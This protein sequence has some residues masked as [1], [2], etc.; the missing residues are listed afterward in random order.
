[1]GTHRKELGIRDRIS[2]LRHDGPVGVSTW[3]LRGN[4][5]K[6][7]PD[8][9]VA[10]TTGDRRRLGA[11]HRSRDPLDQACMVHAWTKAAT[12]LARIFAPDRLGGRVM[13]SDDPEVKPYTS[14]SQ[15]VTCPEWRSGLSGAKEASRDLVGHFLVH[16]SFVP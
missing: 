13:C 12:R 8:Q 5:S 15:R 11:G 4:R 1:L 3:G 10:R 7:D 6:V 9:L 16:R 2:A 14:L